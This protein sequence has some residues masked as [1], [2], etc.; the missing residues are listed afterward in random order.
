MSV[1]S[2]SN[3]LDD[4]KECFMLHAHCNANCTGQRSSAWHRQT[5]WGPMYATILFLWTEWIIAVACKFCK[6]FI[7][8]VVCPAPSIIYGLM[9][10]RVESRQLLLGTRSDAGPE[11]KPCAGGAAA[12]TPLTSATWLPINFSRR[13]SD[14]PPQRLDSEGNIF[15]TT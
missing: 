7:Q 5:V 3:F 15:E 12:A 13:F 10:P 2:A 1:T 6:A 8:R 9:L 4:S 11:C 14:F